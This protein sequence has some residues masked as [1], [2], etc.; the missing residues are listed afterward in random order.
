MAE[1]ARQL[2]PADQP[3][4]LVSID[5]LKRF[6]WSTYYEQHASDPRGTWTDL[7]KLLSTL[8]TLISISPMVPTATSGRIG[9]PLLSQNTPLNPQAEFDLYL[10][11]QAANYLPA[12]NSTLF[13]SDVLMILTDISLGIQNTAIDNNLPVP[14]GITL[15]ERRDIQPQSNYVNPNAI[16]QARGM[17]VEQ[18]RQLAVQTHQ[19]F[20]PNEDAE[21]AAPLS[22]LET[23]PDPT[24]AIAEALAEESIRGEEAL[25]ARQAQAGTDSTESTSPAGA[26][27]A[28]PATA[29]VPLPE[30]ALGEIAAPGIAA[31]G[32]VG[33]NLAGNPLLDNLRSYQIE[34]RRIGSMLTYDLLNDLNISPESLSPEQFQQLEM[35]AYEL[36]YTYLFDP[37]NAETLRKLTTSPLE[38][39]KLFRKLRGD[40][41]RTLH[42]QPVLANEVNQKINERAEEA[43]QPVSPLREEPTPSAS[44][45]DQGAE[46]AQAEAVTK[47]IELL[48][49]IQ[50]IQPEVEQQLLKVAELPTWQKSYEKTFE[51]TLIQ[52]FGLNPAD[53]IQI[54]TRT[55]AL[56]ALLGLETVSEAFLATKNVNQPA[57][58][59]QLLGTQF[60]STM[61]T[62]ELSNLIEIVDAYAYHKVVDVVS[63]GEQIHQA[64]G[65]S[66]PFALTPMMPLTAKERQKVKS[67]PNMLLAYV[68]HQSFTKDGQPTDLPP[69]QATQALSM[70]AADQQTSLLLAYNLSGQA[71]YQY[72]KKLFVQQLFR[73][74]I[75]TYQEQLIQIFTA[76]QVPSGYWEQG[77][78][79]AQGMNYLYNSG[80]SMVT[81]AE[82]PGSQPNPALEQLKELAYLA[83]RTYV[84][85]LVPVLGGI[86]MDV[87][88][89][90]FFDAITDEKKRAELVQ[91]IVATFAMM[92]APL[93]AMLYGLLKL[94]SM[95]GA[96]LGG[97]IGA[98]IG[99]VLGSVVPGVGTLLGAGI[100]GTVGS[101]LGSQASSLFGGGGG[102]GG[103]LGLGGGAAGGSA[104]STGLASLTGSTGFLALTSGP[105]LVGA[106]ITMQ[107]IAGGPEL[108]AL[109]MLPLPTVDQSGT[110]SPYL[111][112]EKRAY[113]LADGWSAGER[114]QF[115]YSDY[116]DQATFSQPIKYTV[117]LKPKDEYTVTIPLSEVSDVITVNYNSKYYQD[118]GQPTPPADQV[119]FAQNPRN[120]AALIAG[121][122]CPE[123]VLTDEEKQISGNFLGYYQTMVEVANPDT[124]EGNIVLRPGDELT[125]PPYCETY[126]EKVNQANVTNTF[127]INRLAAIGGASPTDNAFAQTA[128]VLCFGKCPQFENGCWPASGTIKQAA[129][130]P[131]YSH[132]LTD[133]VDISNNLGTPV[134]NTFQGTLTAYQ[135]FSGI[136]TT[137]GKKFPFCSN[138]KSGSG[139]VCYPYGNH[140][141]GEYSDGTKSFALIFAHLQKANPYNNTPVAPGE[142]IGLMGSTGNSTGSHLHYEVRIPGSGFGGYTSAVDGGKSYGTC[143]SV[144]LKGLVPSDDV[145]CSM[146]NQFVRSCYDSNL[147]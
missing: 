45:Q 83:A 142:V 24:K 2:N 94:L 54:K 16:D 30:Q 46:G 131:R 26:T 128:E 116:E 98:G 126:T 120:F 25:A 112:I 11:P 5:Q 108:P 13:L 86:A 7:E 3:A 20:F 10:H 146:V 144:V 137:G 110:L 103:F 79:I 74:T 106:A 27:G 72:R 90:P 61:T 97:L 130:D 39:V 77:Y 4:Q 1:P 8:A 99:G 34:A 66:R 84:Q 139:F 134:Y 31:A 117:T 87:V 93:I 42:D 6:N 59:S 63:Q 37:N 121:S 119:Q 92:A 125:F 64:L 41:A 140:I 141:F 56:T 104:A 28:E 95:G 105:V 132:P 40:F 35:Q 32:L 82:N 143:K 58:M 124:G 19:S 118:A 114:P 69:V 96:L 60:A 57:L 52:E 91:G 85:S 138:Q 14:Q 107:S 55:E 76:P 62:A 48:R 113:D 136:T 115:N 51:N 18:A 71:A 89:K 33:S 73:P 43:E 68:Q 17:L 36:S 15:L 38:R 70:A 9:M 81:M 88:A 47:P 78:S 102:G 29:K 53:V 122:N 111:D 23:E 127:S 109:L 145:N 22:E 44:T 65:I 123:D 67:Q 50:Q 133:A 147:E 101:F 49:P 21:E 75:F 135:Q 100:G 12:D 80:P 129:H